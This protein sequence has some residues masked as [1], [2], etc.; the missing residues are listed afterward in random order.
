MRMLMRKN[1]NAEHIVLKAEISEEE[2]LALKDFL[3]EEFIIE[4]I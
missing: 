2:F 4:F 1:K 3:D